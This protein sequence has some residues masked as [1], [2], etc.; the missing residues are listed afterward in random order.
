[1]K[2][3]NRF[4]IPKN[5][6]L[7]ISLFC[8][9][10]L[11]E[12]PCD[13]SLFDLAFTSGYIWKND[14]NFKQTYGN[15]I[16]DYITADACFYPL[17]YAGVGVKTSYWEAKGKTMNMNQPAKLYEVPLIGYLRL[18]YGYWLQGYVSLGGGAIFLK[19]KS[20]LGVVTQIVGIG[21]A[22]IGFNYFPHTNFYLTGAF[23]YLFPRQKSSGE[24]VDFGGY[25]LRGGIGF[26]Y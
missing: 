16:P 24:T 26:C 18:R 5:L 14:H 8:S 1:M 10:I 4:C 2:S 6:F 12:K 22:E 20:Y 17:T 11:A 15:G 19:E 13:F 21:E 3:I 25:G 23:R 9:S 7:I